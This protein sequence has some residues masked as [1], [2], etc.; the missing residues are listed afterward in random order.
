M[1]GRG[2]DVTKGYLIQAKI[3]EA[4]KFDL[5]G[6]QPFGKGDRVF[7][8]YKDML[9]ITQESYVWIYSRTGIS[10]LRAGSMVETDP[11]RIPEM[12]RQ[13]LHGFMMRAFMSWNGDYRLGDLG[14]QSLEM[15]TEEVRVKQA[16]LIY[17]NEAR[18]EE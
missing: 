15:M 8:Q 13:S 16:I 1:S 9:N 2:F 4:L 14:K 3:V 7:K 10:I 12:R 6:N 18:A 11:S 17:A 5:I